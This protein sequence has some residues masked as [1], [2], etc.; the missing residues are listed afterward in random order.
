L[1]RVG[2]FDRFLIADDITGQAFSGEQVALHLRNVRPQQRTFG[3]RS[4]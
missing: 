1:Q 2:K 4:R 3:R